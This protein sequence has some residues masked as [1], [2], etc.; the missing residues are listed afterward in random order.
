[1]DLRRY[2]D[3]S[4]DAGKR[5]QTIDGFGVNINSKY[6]NDG[7]LIPVMDL[8]TDDLG[9]TLF[10]LDAY[11]K[12]NWID[13]E[14]KYDASILNQQTYDQVYQGIEFENAA[15]MGKH[16]NAKGIE[17]YITLSG[18][19]PR[20]MCAGDGKTLAKYDEFAE[21]AVSYL[22]WLRQKACV[23]FHLFGPLNETDLGPPEGPVVSPAGYRE[24]LEILADKLDQAGLGDLKLVAA[25]QS[26]Y[27]LDYVG[28][29][30][31]SPKLAGRMGVFGM[32]CYRDFHA[33][34]LVRLAQNSPYR[35]IRLWMTEY[36]DLD[37]SGE[38]EWYVA[39]V[40]CQRLL[41]LLGDGL[42]A[43]LNWDAFDNYHDHNEAWTI[44]G[45]I[46]TGLRVHTPKK[47]YY[48]CRQVYRYVRPGFVRIEARTE[49]PGVTVLAFISPDGKH[50]TVAGMNES[51]ENFGLNINV[52]NM[53]PEF[54]PTYADI[55]RTTVDENCA[56]VDRV[57][58]RSE[59]WPYT[60]IQVQ[61]P[62]GSIFTATTLKPN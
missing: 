6:W 28:E 30:L 18:I 57:P 52:K 50:V 8:L 45:L 36:G 60:G 44:Y 61:A 17:P 39:W 48:A 22:I 34:E 55:F 32:H 42:N 29:I 10:R 5:F 46:R 26:R 35:D 56:H 38:R 53:A 49:A 3:I 62:A 20:W 14:N 21:M 11:G 40:T 37:Q 54:N 47:R 15:A 31:K 51:P 7:K 33:D 59:N 25:E 19:V 9:A 58:V 23:K 12:S 13:P 4:V 27:D 2:A 1:M 43:A 16:L 41:R 24:V